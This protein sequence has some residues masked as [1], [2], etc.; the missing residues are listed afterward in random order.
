MDIE[1]HGHI[2]SENLFHSLLLFLTFHQL[3]CFPMKIGLR[4]CFVAA[5]MCKLF[6][7]MLISKQV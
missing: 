7:K 4:F 3:S 6:H 5:E 2:H 1:S